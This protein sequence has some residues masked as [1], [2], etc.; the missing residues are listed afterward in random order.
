MTSFIS[1]QEAAELEVA[2]FSKLVESIDVLTEA[3]LITESFDDAKKALVKKLK[4]AFE[5]I[6]TFINAI[7]AKLI[8]YAERKL[9]PKVNA[10]CQKAR[11][12][13]QENKLPNVGSIKIAQ[14]SF[15]KPEKNEKNVDMSDE[16]YL[17]NIKA[18]KEIIAKFKD[19]IMNTKF[20]LDSGDKFND[21]KYDIANKAKATRDVDHSK[22]YDFIDKNFDRKTRFS[23]IYMNL[24]DQDPKKAVFK[25]ANYISTQ[26]KNISE[27][28]KLYQ[29]L[30]KLEGVFEKAM[31][32]FTG[33]ID[34]FKAGITDGIVN[35]VTWKE[36]R[37]DL[38]TLKTIANT[39]SGLYTGYIK[40]II[41]NCI[42]LGKLLHDKNAKIYPDEFQVPE[43]DYFDELDY[44]KLD[45]EKGT[46]E[47]LDGKQHE[48]EFNN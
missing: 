24:N 2:S 37:S 48:F 31:S 21:N 34:N 7:K 1:I 43:P 13:A 25:L 10:L 6:K 19:A 26:T 12:A 30:L 20:S 17:N 45:Y 16:D 47:G 15:Y 14:L 39:V 18:N 9:T 41:A 38:E 40:E 22:V 33:L 8:S 27:L 5:K 4:T 44:E 23:L 46:Y 42:T 28:G 3:G 29:G 11:K 36:I 32:K 35:R